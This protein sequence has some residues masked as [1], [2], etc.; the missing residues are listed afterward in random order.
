MR[1]TAALL[2]YGRSL[3]GLRRWLSDT[4]SFEQARRCVARRFATREESFLRLLRGCVFGNPKSPYTP[5]LRAAGCAYEDLERGVRQHGIESEL[6]R[7]RD[8]GVWISL[9]ELKGRAPI[10]RK[11]V[12][13]R[14][15]ASDFD[16]PSVSPIVAPGSS[17][18]SGR[19]VR[20]IIDLDHLA[21]RATYQAFFLELLGLRGVQLAV[22]YPQLPAPSGVVNSLL[23]AKLG[24]PPLRWF[25]IRYGQRGWSGWQ[26]RLLTAE[27]V[28]ASRSSRHRLAWPEPGP[29]DAVL[30]WIVRVRD[31]TGHCAVHA[32]VSRAV[33]LSQAA[34][35]RGWSLEGVAFHLGAEPITPSRWHEIRAS[36]ARAWPRY[37]SSEM[38]TIGVGC[39]DPLEVDDVHLCRDLVAVVQEDVPEPGAPYALYLT[40]LHEAAPKV[41]VNVQL[42]DC[43]R[44][45]RR[46]CGCILGQ[47][48]LDLHLLQ[49]R[50]IGRVTCEGMTVAVWELVRIVEEVLC[51]RYGGSPLDYQWVEREERRGKGR[52]RLRVSPNV[53][54]GDADRMARDVLEEF[55]RHSQSSRIVAEVWHEAG[56]LEVAHERPSVTVAG[57]TLPF[58]RE[59]PA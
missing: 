53:G 52:L 11:D 30:R 34:C 20:S 12:D 54:A 22:W 16:N 47:M 14:P 27:L 26:G 33:R 9:E 15:C 2:A 25:D 23:H 17:G 19:P 42:G 39:A 1:A 56:T 4:I 58:M 5:L 41:M 38:G 59:A 7:L 46:R 51:S 29:L 28:A 8:A 36:G 49:L 45:V 6:R 24:Q 40:S 37:A 50:S 48:G 43:A 18:S 44:V 32:Y 57:K 10:V 21:V 35:A 3:A 13:L 55:A 31:R